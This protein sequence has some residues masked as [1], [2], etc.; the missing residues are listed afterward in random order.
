MSRAPY[1]AQVEGPENE[2]SCWECANMCERAPCWPTPAQ[3]ASL[4]N[5]GY[6]GRLAL[7]S[8]D[9]VE[10]GKTPI[11]ATWV[12]VEVI[13]PAGMGRGGG[14]GHRLPLPC[15]FLTDD[16]E[17]EIHT[18]QNAHGRPLKPLEGR[19][20]SCKQEHSDQAR[21]LRYDVG[22]L[23]RTP[24]GHAVVNKWMALGF[25]E[26]FQELREKVP[27]FS[28]IRFYPFGGGSVRYGEVDGHGAETL[29]VT[30]LDKH[31]RSLRDMDYAKQRMEVEI[32][33]DIIHLGSPDMS[34]WDEI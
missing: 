20:A 34:K 6:G 2:C 31:G 12:P 4:I 32:G 33:K 25:Y 7:Y 19:L 18:L 24:V 29:L 10:Y 5:L 13:A 28:R 21:T 9:I 16:K 15:T 23:W 27:M 11:D 1:P 22:Q 17:C 8:R 3:A 14:E 26:R 30:L